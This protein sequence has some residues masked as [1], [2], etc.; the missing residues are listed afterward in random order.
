MTISQPPSTSS[1][2]RSG[3][4]VGPLLAMVAIGVGVVI[5]LGMYGA[6]HTPTRQAVNIA[7]FSS[8]IYTKAWLTTAAFVLALVQII[9]AAIMFGKINISNPPSWIG[10]LHRWSGR[11][12]VLLTVPVAVH[13]LYALGFQTDQPRVL[14]HAVFGCLFYGAF[15]TKM[16]ALS[17]KG[18]PAGAL[19]VI[20]GVV[21]TALVGLWCTAGLWLFTTQGLHF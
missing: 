1:S 16:L 21:F 20:G 9:T 12:A 17:S 15:V 4:A 6:L 7:G 3:T 19:P 2:P 18:I 5:L 10:G 11:I 13:C 8:G 14:I